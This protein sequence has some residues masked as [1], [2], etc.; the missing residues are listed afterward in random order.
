MSLN[1]VLFF[2]FFYVLDYWNIT[3]QQLGKRNRNKAFQQYNNARP[4]SPVYMCVE[5][6]QKNKY[7]IKDLSLYLQYIHKS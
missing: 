6:A 5:Y 2:F 7:N 3:R 4:Q 1:F